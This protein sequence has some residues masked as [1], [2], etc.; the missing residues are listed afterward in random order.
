MNTSCESISMNGIYYFN[1]S[2]C[3]ICYICGKL[4]VSPSEP[5]NILRQYDDS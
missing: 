4:P 1:I 5:E 2:S 3:Q